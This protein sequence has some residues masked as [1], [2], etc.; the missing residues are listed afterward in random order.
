MILT[1]FKGYSKPESVTELPKIV[2]VSRKP[3][4]VQEILQQFR[5]TIK[6]NGLRVSEFFRDFDRLRLHSIKKNDFIRGLAGIHLSLSEEEYAAVANYYEDPK[7]QECSRWTD[8]KRDMHN[9]YQ[10]KQ[11]IPESKMTREEVAA[12]ESLIARIRYHL[13]CRQVSIKPFF[14]DFDKVTFTCYY[15]KCLIVSCRSV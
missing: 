6:N 10:M 4:D 5:W 13:Q 2:A 9:A 8:F 12:F 3:I 7:R 11:L 15:Y 1:L 14:R